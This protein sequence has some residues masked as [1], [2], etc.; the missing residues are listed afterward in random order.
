MRAK[1]WNFVAVTF[2]YNSIDEVYVNAYVNTQMQ[3]YVFQI[4]AATY[5]LTTDVIT[6]GSAL[7][8][9]TEAFYIKDFAL[10]NGGFVNNYQ[11][12]GYSVSKLPKCLLRYIHASVPSGSS[13]CIMCELG[14]AL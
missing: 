14:Y 2:G 1:F 9:N 12:D 3:S 4:D 6:L 7:N 8:Q 13:Y 10:D 5:W 11:L